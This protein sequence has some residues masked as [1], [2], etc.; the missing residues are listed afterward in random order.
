[1]KIIFLDIDGVLNSKVY[2]RESTTEDGNIDKTR[3]PLVKRIVDETG[4]KIV[5]S[6]TWRKHW[7]REYACLDKTGKQLVDTLREAGLEIYDKTPYHE[8]YDRP[9]EIRE[10]LD[11]HG[12]EV[13]AFVILD[14]A[15]GFGD[16]SDNLVKTDP[17]IGR[18]L[19]EKHV[20]KAIAILGRKGE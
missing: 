20:E 10:W 12:G 19:M 3:L 14:D 7:V 13:E 1:M 6:T 8:R 11:E 9:G 15:F 17:G 18:G 4:A 5:L 2:D 16:L